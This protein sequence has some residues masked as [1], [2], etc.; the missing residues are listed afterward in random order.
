MPRES[1][2]KKNDRLNEALKRL[3]EAYPDARPA[4]HY[5]TPF[6]LLIAV[7]LS[8]QC[9]DVRVNIVTETLFEK[10]NTPEQFASITPDELLPWIKSCGLGPAKSK[11]IVATSKMLCEQFGGKVPKVLQTLPGVGRKTANVVASVAYG[12]PAIAVDTH[13]FRV[14]NRIGLA[15][16]KDV[17]NTEKQLMERIPKENWAKAH[18]WLIFHGRRVCTARSPKCGECTVAPYCAYHLANERAEQAKT[19][20]KRAAQAK[21]TPVALA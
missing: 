3:E 11:N 18:H 1:K 20:K 12:V 6:E 16:A 19:A 17:T 9:T 8:A 4:L 13:V 15:D 5:N 2:V 7:M 10:W 14:S 21:E